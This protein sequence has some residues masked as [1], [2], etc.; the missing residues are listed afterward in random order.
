MNAW[1]SKNPNVIGN[2]NKPR[3]FKTFGVKSLTI[4]YFAYKKAWMTSIIFE[5]ILRN[6]N[7][8][9]VVEGREILL[10]LDNATHHP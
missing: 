7:N 9:M 3:A 4:K 1:I 5:K 2:T 6:L 10:Y 8:E